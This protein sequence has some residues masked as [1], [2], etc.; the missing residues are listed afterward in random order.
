MVW[1]YGSL[2]TMTQKKLPVMAKKR[3]TR[4]INAHHR[5]PCTYLTLMGELK[6]APVYAL[7]RLLG[8]AQSDGHSFCN[9]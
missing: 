7:S 6:R 3:I 8:R 5:F 9:R 4:S 1:L 2:W